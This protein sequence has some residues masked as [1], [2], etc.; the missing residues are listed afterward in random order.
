MPQ[1]VLM[2]Q[3]WMLSEQRFALVGDWL[4]WVKLRGGDIWGR[5]S[6]MPLL[7]SVSLTH[8][9]AGPVAR[10]NTEVHSSWKHAAYIMLPQCL[11]PSCVLHSQLSHT[12]ELP[13]KDAGAR[14]QDWVTR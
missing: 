1:S 6:G 9:L 2:G 14:W 5:I 7:V 12:W 13:A 11:L 4:L 3:I 8:M 10:L